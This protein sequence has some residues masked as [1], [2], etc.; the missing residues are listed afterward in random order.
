MA[1]RELAHLDTGIYYG[2]ASIGSSDTRYPMVMSLG[3]NPYY[4]NEKRSAEVHIIHQFPK[5]FYGAEQRCIVL[6][7]IRPEQDYSCLDDLIEDIK[8]DI[9]VALACLDRPNYAK[10]RNADFLKPD[11]TE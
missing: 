10:L 4:K 2:W 8:F 9:K 3:W 6:G 5:D 11:S 7:Y 1:D